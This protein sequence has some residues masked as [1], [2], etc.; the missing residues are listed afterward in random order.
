MSRRRTAVIVAALLIVFFSPLIVRSIYFFSRDLQVWS[1][2]QLNP[3]PAPEESPGHAV[4]P[5]EAGTLILNASVVF[6]GGTP[7]Q[8]PESFGFTLIVNVTNI[9]ESNIS[10][11][12]VVKATAFK[13][14]LT[15]VFTF[16]M[17]TSENATI[18]SG[19]NELLTYVE[20]RLVPRGTISYSYYELFLRVLITFDVNTEVIVT[21][22][23][24]PVMFWIE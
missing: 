15:P 6:S 10:D 13:P 9:G 18:S 21:T 14:D 22:P 19:A 17:T 7:H 23:L 5:L 2:P 3:L 16:G 20:D 8:G 24:T 12:H 1:T 4:A 11:F